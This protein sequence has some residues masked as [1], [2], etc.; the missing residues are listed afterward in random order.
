MSS[1]RAT[2]RRARRWRSSPQPVGL[3]PRLRFTHRCCP[4]R[5]SSRLRSRRPASTIPKQGAVS[6]AAGLRGASPLAFWAC[7]DVFF[8]RRTD[9]KAETRLPVGAHY[10]AGKLPAKHQRLV[11]TLADYLQVDRVIGL[12]GAPDRAHEIDRA[13][14]LYAVR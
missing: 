2:L 10:L 14:D 13:L 4:K 6:L 9:Q 5:G 7:V 11:L 8:S 12:I 1:P 3:W